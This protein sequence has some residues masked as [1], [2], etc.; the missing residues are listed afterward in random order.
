MKQFV[1]KFLFGSPGTTNKALIAS[2]WHHKLYFD[3]GMI[4]DIRNIALES[5]GYRNDSMFPTTSEVILKNGQNRSL[6]PRSPPR[7][8]KAH[9]NIII[10]K[11]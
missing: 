3:I 4:F 10:N 7:K 11:Y 2:F 8:N 1:I 5:Y 6:P 9:R